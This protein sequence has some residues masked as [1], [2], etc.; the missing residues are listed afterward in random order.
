MNTENQ[1]KH[2]I[3]KESGKFEIF[4]N[5]EKAGELTYFWNDEN[6]FSIDHTQVD[7][8]FSGRGLAK[9]LVVAAVQYARE[10]N[11]KIVPLCPY[12]ISTIERN[13][14]LQDVL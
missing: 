3:N 8:A 11:K 7:E 6:Q 12:A 5:S 2:T 10:E 13:K 9:Q 1:I 4:V 14:E